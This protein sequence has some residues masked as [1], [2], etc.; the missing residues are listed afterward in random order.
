ML[1]VRL[2]VLGLGDDLVRL[3]VREVAVVGQVDEV[4]DELVAPGEQPEHEQRAQQHPQGPGEPST[5]SLVE[6]ASHRESLPG[7]GPSGRIDFAH[8]SSISGTYAD[9]ARVGGAIGAA[10]AADVGAARSLQRGHN[11]FVY[12]PQPDGTVE[13]GCGFQVAEPFEPVGE[14]VCD[15]IEGG[16]AAHA[17]HLGPYSELKRTWDALLADLRA[18]G[19]PTSQVQW[20]VYG[21]WQEDPAQLRTDVYVP[22]RPDATARR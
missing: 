21:D 11:V 19:E 10:M 6:R 7:S 9:L 12:R 1:G 3:G 8:R 16:E 20:E 22:V 5:P 2:A 4:L 18:A 17:L 14:V 15:T 13:L